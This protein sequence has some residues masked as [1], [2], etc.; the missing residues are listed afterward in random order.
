MDF[1]LFLL[2]SIGSG[3]EKIIEQNLE[4]PSMMDLIYTP[5]IYIPL[6]AFIGLVL[7]SIIAR[8]MFY[9]N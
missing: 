3:L 6:I 2:V 4:A 7:I 5:D 8:K 9:K 1:F